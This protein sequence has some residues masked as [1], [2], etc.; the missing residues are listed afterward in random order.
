M[1]PLD[2]TIRIGTRGSKLARWQ[3]DWVAGELRKLGV[4]VEIVE[5]ATQGDVQQQGPVASLG[6]QGLFTKE[7]QTAVLQGRVDLAVHSLKDLPTQQV[8]GLAL[9]ATPPREDP[10]DAL[11]TNKAETLAELSPGACVGTGSLRR[12]AQLLH[13]RPDLEVVGIRGNV[14]TRLRKLDEGEYDAIVLAAAGLERLGWGDRIKERLSPPRMLPAPGQGALGIECRE[15]DGEAIELMRQLD[16]LPTRLGVTAE[17]TVLGAL[18]GGCSAPI[19]AWGRV[20]DGRLLVDAL[21]A[22]VEGRRVLR[23]EKVGE[24]ARGG[25]LVERAAEVGR[26]VADELLE[27]GAAELIATA[28]G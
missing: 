25:D 21:V 19:A 18:H 11:V 9:T 16:D 27:Q 2:R 20:A 23:A 7:I 1:K 4:E 17:R 28:R 24:L 8:A 12:R 3:S 13:L 15:D 5:I 26:I 22:E 14:D 10:A 6:I